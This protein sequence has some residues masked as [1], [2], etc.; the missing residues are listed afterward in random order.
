[1]NE[2]AVIECTECGEQGCDVCSGQGRIVID[3]C[4]QKLIDSQTAEL[5]TF[6]KLYDKGLPPVQGGALDQTKSFIS[7]CQFV[8]SEQARLKN[9]AMAGD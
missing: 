5:L 9:E 4:P 7:A 8:W 1:V 3:C 6:A 2:P